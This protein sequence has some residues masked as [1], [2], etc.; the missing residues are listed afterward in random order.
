MSS[1]LEKDELVCLFLAIVVA[2]LGVLAAFWPEIR[3]LLL[4]PDAFNLVI[5]V[6]V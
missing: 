4:P 1:E 2:T 6:T 3:D 5:N